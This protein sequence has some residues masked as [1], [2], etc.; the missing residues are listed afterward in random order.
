MDGNCNIITVTKLLVTAGHW[1][2]RASSYLWGP[3]P[4]SGS[5]ESRCFRLHSGSSAG[6]CARAL[7]IM[8]LGPRHRP[9][10]RSQTDS[11]PAPA[12]THRDHITVSWSASDELWRA[13]ELNN[14][15][16][17]LLVY[18]S[19]AICCI[20]SCRN[21]NVCLKANDDDD[22]K[23]EKHTHTRFKKPPEKLCSS[24][25]KPKPALNTN[26]AHNKCW[27][28]LIDKDNLFLTASSF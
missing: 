17:G 23:Q 26:D 11:P 6:W 18:Y 1:H 19:E 22:M 12:Q 21:D 13:P 4:G 5:D 14:D 15:T 16:S 25:P 2:T 10:P 8:P 27:F 7:P 3:A 24:A 20:K 28:T 9:W